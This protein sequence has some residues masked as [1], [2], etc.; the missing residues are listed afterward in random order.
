MQPCR[1]FS[2]SVRFPWRDRSLPLGKKWRRRF[3]YLLLLGLLLSLC[4]QMLSGCT[5][6]FGEP[7]QF[8]HEICIG[9]IDSLTGN[10]AESGRATV[11]A[12]TLATQEVNRAGGL[13]IRGQPH[14]V[15][16]I[17]KDT[18]SS[19]EVAASVAQSL[20][21]QEN[22]VAIVGPQYSRYAIPVSGLAEQARIPM[23]SPRS[24]N[25][26]TTAGKRYVFRAIFTDTV[27]GEIIAR[28][29]HHD[30]RASKAAVLYDIA[31][32]YNRGIADV[33]KRIFTQLGGR[34]V[35]F[36][37]YTTGE[38]DF[39]AQL[40]KIQSSKPDVLFL[41]N[42][43]NEVP[44]QAQQARQLRIQAILLG[45]DAWGGMKASDR[46]WLE[47]AYFSDHFIPGIDNATTQK[48]IQRYRQA[49]QSEPGANA[50][51]TYD[52]M[53][54]LFSVIQ[55]QGRTDAESIRQGIANFGQYQ[56]VTGTL[57]YRGTG[58][59]IVSVAILQIRD[60]K[61]SYFKEIAPMP[62]NLA[63]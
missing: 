16:L 29:A 24:T 6:S 27:Q 55:K 19:P 56:G 23:I 49:Y 42:Y 9:I 61:T 2:V 30:L 17:I 10:D 28:F 57:E 20:I 46:Q 63:N 40:R 14:Q 38:R 44:L 36:E 52:S 5:R 11:D 25:P 3:G 32:P 43:E 15:K 58:D 54:L 48:F 8:N 50:A 13:E 45:A 35:A 18:Q 4:L 34:M 41:P 22:I 39:S 33:F 26:E 37:S 59:P 53:G 47:G 51:A 21:T 62:Q 31:S 12:A 60:G 7:K 1:E